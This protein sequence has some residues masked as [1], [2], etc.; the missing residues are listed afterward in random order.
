MRTAQ[1]TDCEL[2]WIE[3]AER[4]LWKMFGSSVIQKVEGANSVL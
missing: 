3:G 4:G 2:H 1:V